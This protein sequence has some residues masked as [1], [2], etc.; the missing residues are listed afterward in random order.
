MPVFCRYR[1]EVNDALQHFNQARKDTEWGEKALFAMI[2][3]CLNPE[4]ELIAGEML[5]P[6]ER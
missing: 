2:E 6:I 4:G 3:I 1:H 5:K